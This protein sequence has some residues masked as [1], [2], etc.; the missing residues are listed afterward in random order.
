ML[1]ELKSAKPL[2][3]TTTV[4]IAPVSGI[5][6]VKNNEQIIEIEVLV[7][8][9]VILNNDIFVCGADSLWWKGIWEVK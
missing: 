7:D 4:S 3:G 6:K 5:I 1:K 9:S 2:P 8:G